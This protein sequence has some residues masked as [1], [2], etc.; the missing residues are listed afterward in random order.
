MHK[1]MAVQTRLANTGAILSYV[2]GLIRKAQ[3]E[4]KLSTGLNEIKQVSS[5]M[6]VIMKE[7]ARGCRKIHVIILGSKASLVAVAIKAP[8]R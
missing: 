7:Q 4:L 1:A 3:D 5:V 8:A 6:S 2:R